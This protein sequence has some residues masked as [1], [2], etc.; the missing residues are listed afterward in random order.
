M[1]A[2]PSIVTRLAKVCG[3]LGSDHDGERSA[4]ALKATAILR[5]AGMTWSDLFAAPS[6]AAPHGSSTASG[7][8]VARVARILRSAGL[9]TP[10]EVSF[11]SSLR[12]R[13]SLSPRQAELLAEIEAKVPPGG[14]A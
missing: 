3:L 12:Q 7:S 13:R 2:P 1:T 4:A 5:S 9:L 10:W 14:G 8:H 6:Q 11:L